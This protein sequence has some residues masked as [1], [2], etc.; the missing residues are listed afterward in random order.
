MKWKY[1]FIDGNYKKKPNRK[2]RAENTII[3]MNNSLDGF[4][5]RF[6]QVEERITGL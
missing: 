1:Q 6:K 5:N 2:S 4:N 3:E